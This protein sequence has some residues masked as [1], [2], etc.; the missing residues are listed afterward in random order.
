MEL[1]FLKDQQQ[2]V[3]IGNVEP[4]R[5]NVIVCGVFGSAIAL[6]NSSAEIIAC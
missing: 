1:Y 2:S 3:A 4:S 5:S 6:F